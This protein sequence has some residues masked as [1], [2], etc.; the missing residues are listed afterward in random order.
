MLTYQ[1]PQL[2]MDKS[3]EDTN[4]CNSLKKKYKIWIYVKYIKKLINNLK[5]TNKENSRLRWFHS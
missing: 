1:V 3:G 5:A 4:C 2:K